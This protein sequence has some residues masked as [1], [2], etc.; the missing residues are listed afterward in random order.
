MNNIV[1][2]LAKLLPEFASDIEKSLK[3]TYAIK[4][5]SIEIN[6]RLRTFLY[7]LS[8]SDNVHGYTSAHGENYDTV[9]SEFVGKLTKYSDI[10]EKKL[11]KIAELTKQLRD[12]E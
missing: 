8:C 2:E 5:F 6:S 12:G 11:E 7:S 10:R 3:D 1:K 4:D 9:L